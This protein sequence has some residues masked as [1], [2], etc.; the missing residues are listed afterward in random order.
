MGGGF[1][2]GCPLIV[3]DTQAVNILRFFLRPPSLFDEFNPFGR[4]LDNARGPEL[5]ERACRKRLRAGGL[6]AS[7]RRSADKYQVIG[8]KYQECLRCVRLLLDT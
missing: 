2:H 4:P 7:K 8:N 5:V 1:C 6:T 3:T